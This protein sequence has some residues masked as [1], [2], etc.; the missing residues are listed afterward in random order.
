[1]ADPPRILAQMSLPIGEAQIAEWHW[2]SPMEATTC[3]DRHMI[4]MSLPPLATDGTGC[5]PEIA[6]RRFSHIGNVF[7]RPA[8]LQLYS[9]SDGGHIRIVRLAVSRDCYEATSGHSIAAD[10]DI[11]RMCL[12]LRDDRPRGLLKQIHGELAAPGFASAALLEAYGTALI[13]ETAR[14]IAERQERHA[15]L[16]RLAGWQYRRVCERIEAEGP[17]PSLAELASL[18]GVSIRHFNRLY[19]AL[20]GENVTA[21]IA[22]TQVSRAMVLLTDEA[23]PLKEV[24]A[25]LGFTHPGSFSAAFRRATGISPSRYRQQA[26]WRL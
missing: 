24:A 17:A 12:D 19:R 5:F 3:E 8:G 22:R 21:H 1:M 6:P 20:T 7:L 11:L 23:L 18:C 15:N 25:R 2:P 10:P 26:K 14:S 4:E 9:R 13:I 16:G